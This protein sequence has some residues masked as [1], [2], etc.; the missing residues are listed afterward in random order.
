MII[1]PDKKEPPYDPTP[2][3]QASSTG[4]N[5]RNVEHALPQPERPEHRQEA[6]P[7]SDVPRQVSRRE[8][9]EP[10]EETALL[11]PPSYNEAVSQSGKARTRRRWVRYAAAVLVLVVTVIGASAVIATQRR[12]AQEANG[13]WKRGGID[14]K[15]ELLR[16]VT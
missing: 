5:A 11:P 1:P 8:E 12:R 10:T 4:Q 13:G 15:G 2:T 3:T 7:P 14:G 6:V 16:L 9:D